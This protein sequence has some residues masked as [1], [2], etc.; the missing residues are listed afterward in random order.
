MSDLQTEMESG[1]LT[2]EDKSGG[3]I[4][5]DYEQLVERVNRQLS[6]LEG[7]QAS[8]QGQYDKLAT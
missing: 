5:L 2:G 7:R 6:S 3:E 4:I 8:L 1:S